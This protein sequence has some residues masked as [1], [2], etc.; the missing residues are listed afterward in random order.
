MI[1]LYTF[2]I[3]LLGLGVACNQPH[4]HDYEKDHHHDHDHAHHDD[5][6]DH[7]HDHSTD[8]TKTM[9]GGLI[10][11]VYFWTKEGTTDEQNTAFEAGLQKLG[12][13]PQIHEYYWG[14]PASTEARGVVDNS[15]TY[16]INVHFKSVEDEHEY[17]N[18]PIH[19]EFIENH[20]D[21][22]EKVV[23]YDNVVR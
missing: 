3:I 14:P 7:D 15:Y 8:K 12:T 6:D 5:H 4:S 13:C 1:R 17:Q 11:T 19:L 23:V 9:K 10:H 22:W 21:I 16:A 2:F 20:K 18:E